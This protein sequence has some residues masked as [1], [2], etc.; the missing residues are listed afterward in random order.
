M[1]DITFGVPKVD[2]HP[3]PKPDRE[4]NENLSS[5]IPD[6]LDT[7][8]EYGTDDARRRTG[9]I[10]INTFPFL[11]V[12]DLMVPSKVQNRGIRYQ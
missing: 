3:L 5:R 9:I 7:N 8:F 4:Y 12:Q 1:Q 10:T 6:A 11:T 2:G